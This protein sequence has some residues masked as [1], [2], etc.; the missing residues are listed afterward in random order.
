MITPRSV[1]DFPQQKVS[2]EEKAKQVDQVRFYQL[3]YRA[4]L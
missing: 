1:C 2:G 4:F 3:H